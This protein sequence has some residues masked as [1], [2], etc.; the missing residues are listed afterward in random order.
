MLEI[1]ICLLPPQNVS[2]KIISQSQKISSKYSTEF[3]LD[4]HTYIP[5]I[6]LYHFPLPEKNLIQVEKKL[7]EIV[8]IPPISLTTTKLSNTESY[9]CWDVIKTPY[10]LSLHDQIL[11]YINPLREGAQRIDLSKH[12]TDLHFTSKQIKYINE[13]AYPLVLD[14]FSPHFTLTRC[15]NLDDAKS[16]TNSP[17]PDQIS[18]QTSSIAIGIIGPHGTLPKIIKEYRLK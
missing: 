10:L 12:K 11:K 17:S 16:I 18:F 8:K 7:K 4:I 5:H 9:I 2:Q 3:T 13:Y 6:S 14:E 15:K 1:N